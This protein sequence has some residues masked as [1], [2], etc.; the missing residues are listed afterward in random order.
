MSSTIVAAL[1][2]VCAAGLIAAVG[3][4]VVL[5]LRPASAARSAPTAGMA[6]DSASPPSR[7]CRA[8]SGWSTS[9]VH[10]AA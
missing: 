3:F 1:L 10:A 8:S 7:A 2:I 4:R 5:K 9:P 6:L